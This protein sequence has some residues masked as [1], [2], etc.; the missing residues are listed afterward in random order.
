MYAITFFGY[1]GFS[2]DQLLGSASEKAGLCAEGGL[3]VWMGVMNVA[4]ILSLVNCYRNGSDAQKKNLLLAKSIQW[5]VWFMLIVFTGP[6]T[7]ANDGGFVG[8]EYIKSCGISFVASVLS[9]HGANGAKTNPAT[10]NVSNNVGK[11]F[12]II[13]FANL[14]HTYNVGVMHSVDYIGASPSAVCQTNN[15]FFASMIFLMSMEFV[16]AMNA[17][18]KYQKICLQVIGSMNVVFFLVTYYQRAAFEADVD[19]FSAKNMW[20]F[21]LIATGAVAAIAFWASNN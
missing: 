20:Q 21:N 14:L 5:A 18:G 17:S 9:R 7:S 16:H 8:V 11:A 1:G 4:F 2:L 10:M 3:N 12:A 13:I 15:G 19:G 6:S